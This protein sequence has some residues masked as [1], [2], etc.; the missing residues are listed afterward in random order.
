MD[1][2]KIAGALHFGAGTVFIA[3]GYMQSPPS[4]VY[5]VLGVVFIFI[6]VASKHLSSG[7][8]KSGLRNF[9]Y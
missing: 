6:G 5:V 9:K 4:R 7:E 2:R 3:I 1:L 8:A